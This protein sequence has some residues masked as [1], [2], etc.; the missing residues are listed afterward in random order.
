MA[1]NTH[2]QQTTSSTC[3]CTQALVVQDGKGLRVRDY[4]VKN[5]LFK[6]DHKGISTEV[7]DAMLMLYTVYMYSISHRVSD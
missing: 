4:H 5:K 3:T 1:Q 7:N 6:D 2:G